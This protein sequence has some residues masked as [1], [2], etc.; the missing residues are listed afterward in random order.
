MAT[1]KETE[2]TSEKLHQGDTIPLGE[3]GKGVP[4]E[5]MSEQD[6]IKAKNSDLDMFMNDMLT[7][8]VHPDIADG[9][10]PVIC[11]N[12]NGINQPIIRGRQAKVKRKYVEVLA[13]SRVTRYEQA[14]PDA[15]KPENIQMVES[16]A[17]TYPFAILDDPHPRGREWLDAILSQK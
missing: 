13:R 17:L 1:K 3:V 15:R 14:T 5:V 4:I 7:I 9:A 12:V 10:L 11:P 2:A 8:L 6:I 16:S